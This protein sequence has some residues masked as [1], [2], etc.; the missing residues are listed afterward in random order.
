V[1]AAERLREELRGFKG[2]R[3]RVGVAGI[4]YKCPPAPVELTFMVEEHL[5]K[6]RFRGGAAAP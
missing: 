4:S 2:G 5:R 1:I 3:I 6:R